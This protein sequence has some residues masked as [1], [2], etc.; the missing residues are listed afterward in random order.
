M[1][2]TN[3][4]LDD[5]CALIGF[6]ATVRLVEWFGGTHIYVPDSAHEKHPLAGVIGY[7]ALRSLSDEFGSQM[8]WVPGDVAGKHRKALNTKKAVAKAL[9]K[10]G[11]TQYVAE[12]LGLSVRQVQRIKRELETA[13]LI[14]SEGQGKNGSKSLAGKRGWKSLPEKWG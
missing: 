11:G 13:G 1:Q 4:T 10:N 5:V 12:S 6:S 14:P 9:L 8:L 7:S 2:N 3:T